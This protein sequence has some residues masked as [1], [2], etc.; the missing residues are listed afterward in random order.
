ME[1]IIH[2]PLVHFEME[3]RGTTTGFHLGHARLFITKSTVKREV[4]SFFQSEGQRWI[5]DYAQNL[6]V[7]I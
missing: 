2:P 4:R 5:V 7:L 1:I 3:S 6:S